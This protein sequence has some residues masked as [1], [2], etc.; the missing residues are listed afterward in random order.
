MLDCRCEDLVD[1]PFAIER[2]T[3]ELLTNPKPHVEGQELQPGPSNVA[4][5]SQHQM[6]YLSCSRIE[7]TT[8]LGGCSNQCHMRM[9]CLS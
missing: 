8:E 3:E 9:H 7:A 1:K 5:A 4:E 2:F 6:S